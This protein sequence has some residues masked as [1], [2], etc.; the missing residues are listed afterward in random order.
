[1]IERDDGGTIQ[2]HI[3]NALKHIFHLL[4]SWEPAILI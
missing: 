3:H 2:K 1:M 4:I